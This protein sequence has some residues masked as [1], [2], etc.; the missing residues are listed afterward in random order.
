[1]TAH[2]IVLGVLMGLGII[3]MITVLSKIWRN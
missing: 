1:M 2:W 3:G